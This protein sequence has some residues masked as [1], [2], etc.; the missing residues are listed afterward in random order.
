M[1]NTHFNYKCLTVNNLDKYYRPHTAIR[2]RIF[3]KLLKYRT[4]KI[5]LENQEKLHFFFRNFCY[6][7]VIGKNTYTASKWIISKNGPDV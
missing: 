2:G 3:V 6:Y 5:Y 1:S 4:V 7:F